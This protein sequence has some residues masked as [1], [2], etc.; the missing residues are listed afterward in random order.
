[1]GTKKVLSLLT[2]IAMI[3]CTLTFVVSAGLPINGNKIDIDD[4]AVG[5]Y[6]L[7][8]LE[9]YLQGSY[10]PVSII[11]AEQ[12]DTTIDI[13]L[14]P[15]TDMSAKL[16]AGFSGSGQGML[17]HSGNTCTLSDGK[18]QMT[19]S[20][21]VRMGPQPVASVNYT[22]NFAIDG[23]SGPAVKFTENLSDT[24]L[25]YVKGK[26]ASPLSVFA[27]YTG[28]ET[29]S[30][31]TYQW[32]KSAEKST[33]NGEIID[34]A[35][36]GSYTPQ[37]DEIG[38]IY[39]Y[40]IA[41]CDGLTAIS[42]IATV[43]VQE[44]SL[45]V[46]TNLGD[47]E[48]KYFVG[49]QANALTF[50][51]E[52]TGIT[53][54]DVVYK[55]YKS[56][57]KNA[58]NGE[59]ID[60]A[61]ENSFTPQTEEIGTVYYYATASCEGI[62]VTSNIA[63]VTVTEMPVLS[64]LDNV[65]DIT[66]RTIYTF[67]NRYYANVTS[68]KIDGAVV[69]KASE[70]GTTV[71]VVLDGTTDPYAEI[72][73]EFGTAL[74]RCTM[75]GHTE[76]VT[77]E[78]G[79]AQLV[80]TLTGAYAGSLKGSV[81]YTLNFTLGKAPEVVPERIADADSK[82]TYNGVSVDI[83]LSDYF[84]LAK[85][86]YLVDGEE[87]TPI[88]GNKYTFCAD[89][90]GIYT[91][92]FAAS[93]DTG[94]CPDFVTVTVEVTEIK[95]G[96]WLNIITSNGSVNF[97]KFADAEGKDIDGLTASLK[98]ENIAVTVPRNYNIN[99]KIVATFDLTQKDG[100]PKLSTSN[101]FNSSNDTKVYTTTL[102]L[103]KGKATM[104]LYNAH[105]KASSNNYTTYTISYAVKNETPTI[106]ESQSELV[107]AEI[108]A[109]ESFTLD[110]SPI[111]TDSDGD[112]LSYSVK[113]N[114]NDAVTADKNFSFTPSLGGIYELEFFANDFISTSQESY[115]VTLAVT[116][117][118]VTYN[119]T[120]LVPDET[121]P[122]F[123]ITCGH[124]EDGTDSLGDELSFV[125]GDSDGGYTA[126]SVSVP[127]NISEISVRDEDFGGM[128][129]PASADSKIQLQKVQTK[130][131]D[132]G[133]REISGTVSVSYGGYTAVGVNGSFLLLPE[134]EYTFTAVPENASAFNS[135][136]EKL[137]LTQDTSTVCIKVSY[138]NPKTVIT[139]TG[140]EAALF[141][142]ENNYY[143]HTP[144]KPLAT[145]D[146]GDGTSTHYFAADGN[147][148][149]RVSMDGRITKAGYLLMGNSV[150]VLHTEDDAKPSD[151]VDYA[152]TGT[153]ASS[154]AD[155]S[156]L[157][158]INRDNH[159]SLNVDETKT[160]KAYRAWEIINNYL[161]HI[162]MPDFHFNIVSGDD[163]V[164]ISPYEN[165]PMTNGSGNWCTLT[166][167]GEG[168]AVIEVTYDA[169]E[170]SGGSYDGFYGAT[171]EARTGLFVVTVGENTPDV[172][173]GI[174]SK[175]SAGSIAYREENAKPFDSE[176]DTLY[177]FG[178]SGELKLS[179]SS[180]DGSISELAVSHDK[181]ETYIAV[182]STDG[183]YT[184]PIVSGNNIIRVTTDNGTAY[185][186]IRGD[187]IELFV[188]N[189]THPGKP[190]SAGDKIS[191]KLIGVHT[192]IPKLSGTYNPGY[193]GNTDGESKVHIRYTFDG[194]EIKSPGV[195]Y[196]FSLNGTEIELTV[197]IDAENTDFTLTDGYIGVGVIGVEGFSDD[198]NSHR[199]IPD[200]GSTMRDNNKTTFTTRSILPDITVKIGTLPSGN[201][202]PFIRENAPRTASLTLGKTY[203][204]SMSKV[205]SDR[206]GDSLTYT[207]KIGDG[208]EKT[209][210]DGYFTFTP[211]D[212]GEYIITFIANDGFSESDIH[213]LSL[214][215]KQKSGG[216]SGSSTPEWDIHDD[217]IDGYVKISFTDKGKR[218]KDETNVTYPKALGTII[219]SKK[220]PFGK[221]DT[222][223]D[224]TLRLLDSLGYTYQHTGTTKNGFYLASIGGFT[225]KGIDYDSFGEFDA[226][227]GSGWMIT[228]NEEFIK[229]G[230][231][232]FEVENGDVIKWQ[233]TCQLGKDIGDSYY[234]GSSSIGNDKADDENTK[235]KEESEEPTE[236]K[237]EESERN[238][239]S[240]TT[241]SDV[242]S[243]DWY[244]E[245]V[246][247]GYENG[248]MQ[249][250][251][252]GFEPNGKMTRAMLVT[253]L[254]RLE[255][256]ELTDGE[257]PFTDVEDGTWYTNAV[258]WAKENGIVN[259]ITETEFAPNDNIT[260][261]QTVT[262]FYR[263][264][265]YKGYN[266]KA[267]AD[268]SEFSDS[269]RIS[270]FALDA[271]KW[272]V[273][274]GII[275]GTSENMLSPEDGATRAQLAAILMR[276]ATKEC[277]E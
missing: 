268:L 164:S 245:A 4:K 195:Q 232:D 110:L 225:H 186:I 257:N 45:K 61:N 267:V 88:E 156:L 109:G 23:P 3:F 226:G 141:K 178:D 187:K 100:L 39:Y 184:A 48:I 11:A 67:S 249:G 230:A 233:Y 24:E 255:K 266:V 208:Q 260:R 221:G 56:T 224:V 185:K 277:T 123:Y 212:V 127:E 203:A 181:G 201:T 269:D 57:E 96:L 7:Q 101:S 254:Y 29:E 15:D 111:F 217:E 169:I 125:K 144:I 211:E 38:T 176:L 92:V 167:I 41:S 194:Q 99:G 49:K 44:P 116:N 244:Y 120:V 19:C 68:I 242:K 198:G 160:V 108:V 238:E 204:L 158:N 17:Q 229:Y 216:E 275:N 246:K 18:G 215:V 85:Y 247:Y 264:A 58:E 77:L 146:N 173:F 231:S 175:T 107:M 250:T 274:S 5:P 240:E 84:K 53:D 94:D 149:Y 218:V 239:F 197:P 33:D 95:S 205:F 252:K 97:V 243:D 276:A 115:K 98:D 8:N 188:K 69:E 43:T 14:S 182:D 263:Y 228:L 13:V 272:V 63:T 118:D 256:S 148:S 183:V 138:K 168:T 36:R 200:S 220:V 81:T 121:D 161:N 129:F 271:F 22:I 213:T 214:S 262:I 202:S 119:M 91:L 73:V 46:L 122:S 74:N 137:T 222:V 1:M 253:V 237:T 163:V 52:Y 104:Y 51:A 133:D 170:I 166:A 154:V 192:P 50:D 89:E 78:N 83:N 76:K 90:G 72:S 209:V 35:D 157:L 241:F 165:Q 147:L 114:G 34:G 145:V 258:I 251:E 152:D 174:D 106:S 159:L 234:Q 87:K 191:L 270:T 180:E 25:K 235:E 113:I 131:F 82:E 130:I 16:Q 150:K 140:A 80:M 139:T 20:V 199:N 70:D 248:L 40:V 117:S 60:G 31:I 75:S 93:N 196:D 261:E 79:R 193:S 172:D 55:W 54:S 155:D 227:S 135:A 124:T 162:I 126:Y 189:I 153:D 219:A 207:A 273:A 59:V 65:I 206:D 128:S 32:Y 265:K 12:N 71:N 27:E 21:L 64:V 177:F 171:D 37:T 112:K 30:D 105:P 259:G 136:S 102:S 66:D 142:F 2:C 190:L 223:A 28:G 143:V 210:D 132:L 86:Y 134:N 236:E 10:E 9:V 179:P 151:R 42:K 103:G 26:P 62:T 6:T 47:A